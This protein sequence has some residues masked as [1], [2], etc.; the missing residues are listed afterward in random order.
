MTSSGHPWAALGCAVGGSIWLSARRD[1]VI[2]SLVGWPAARRLIAIDL[3]PMLR[4]PGRRS[5]KKALSPPQSSPASYSNPHHTTWSLSI[6]YHGHVPLIQASYTFDRGFLFADF[7]S[8]L[9]PCCAARPLS[10]GTRKSHFFA[11]TLTPTP[12]LTLIRNFITLLI[13]LLLLCSF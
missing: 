9:P 11:I 13:L 4:P 1:H 3:C 12:T 2:S 10:R 5:V 6:A 8:T 7:R